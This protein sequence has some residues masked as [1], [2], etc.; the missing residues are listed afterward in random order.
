M[1]GALITVIPNRMKVRVHES[2]NSMLI[3][4]RHHGTIS[5]CFRLTVCLMGD[6][7]PS[8]SLLVW[9]NATSTSLEERH[10]KSSNNAECTNKQPPTNYEEIFP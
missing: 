3:T 5:L 4:A 6:P 1:T 7:V 9:K 2:I 10:G 8:Y